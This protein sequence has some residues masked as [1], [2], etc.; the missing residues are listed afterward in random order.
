MLINL[1]TIDFSGVSSGSSANLQ[2][3]K[4]QTITENGTYY[5][6]PDEGYDAMILTK[7]DVNLNLGTTNFTVGKNGQFTFYAKD[8]GLTGMTSVDI[9]VAV[10]QENKSF[11]IPNQWNGS[12]DSV[13]LK[14][15]N[16]TDD[17]I[18]KYQ[19]LCTWMDYENTEH[20]V[21]DYD[22]TLQDQDTYENDTTLQYARN[23]DLTNKTSVTRMYHN[24]SNLKA[25]PYFE[26]NENITT[27]DAIFNGCTNLTVAQPIDFTKLTG[28]T[29]PSVIGFFYGCSSLTIAPEINF[30]TVYNANNFFRNC[31]SL[32]YVPDYKFNEAYTLV[33]FY[34]STAV[35][36]INEVYAPVCQ[37]AQ[38]LF[39]NCHALKKIGRIQLGGSCNQNRMFTD[40]PNLQ[41]IGGFSYSGTYKNSTTCTEELP[42]LTH[43]IFEGAL[44]CTW[45]TGLFNFLPNLDYES[46]KSI[47]TACS[48]TTLLDT[49][50]S[51]TFANITMQDQNGELQALV[52]DCVNNKGWTITGLTITQ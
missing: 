32:K 37:K 41:Y 43:F 13:G 49:A 21:P 45:D 48:N 39:A 51:I 44:N 46:I 30:T 17:Q 2:D 33:S 47:L 1:S 38:Y 6:I 28:Q 9:Y 40:C 22:K 23:I 34:A 25:Y 52:D 14:A 26:L 19:S 42:N 16:W 11:R 20:L 7:V 8:K 35:E 27:S 5:I 29:K 31:S 18:A 4:S 15:L 10:P 12:V 3:I 50:K 36:T 24:C